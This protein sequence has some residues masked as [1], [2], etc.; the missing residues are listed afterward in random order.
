M[1]YF[2]ILGQN[3]T[4]SSAEIVSLL[5]DKTKFL[6]VSPEALLLL[7]EK[8]QDVFDLMARLGGTI[9]IGTILNAFDD[10][11]PEDIAENIPRVHGK[12]SYFGFSF[13]KIDD[14]LPL[15]NFQNKTQKIKKMAMAIKDIL[16][17]TGAAARWVTS[18]EKN[19]SSVVVEKNKLLTEAGAELIFLI[20][21]K[22]TYLGRTLAVQEFENLSFRDYSRPVRSMKVGLLPPKLAK[23]MINLANIDKSATILD[24][25][26]GLGTILGE[27]ALMGY[28]NLTGSDINPEIIAGAKQN[29]EWL[30]KTYNLKLETY[31][32]IESDVRHLGNKL[33]PRSVDAVITE[34]Y[35]GPPMQGNETDEMIKKV[36]EELSALYLAAFREFKKILKSGG[37]IVIAFPV[38]HRKNENLF[39]PIIDEIKKIGFQAAD[40]L[41]KEFTDF[42]FLKI[43]KR[44]STIY[45]R[46]DQKVMREIFIFRH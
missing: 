38:F 8:D 23:I 1:K 17:D 3:P 45:S 43:T 19:L 6:A 36:V 11:R 29:L 28:Q 14:K 41:P 37:K 13:Y 12:K 9:K 34:P 30:S 24:P 5:S 39:L 22:K 27:A 42:N 15:K 10:P 46:P 32:L 44:G 20:D 18:K 26:L 31:N 33:P 4:L 2:F 21:E 16:A 25:F 35:L 40:L 7:T